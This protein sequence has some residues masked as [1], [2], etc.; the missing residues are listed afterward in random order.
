MFA[1]S[2]SAPNVRFKYLIHSDYRSGLH[3]VS[4]EYEVA[5]NGVI[6]GRFAQSTGHFLGN[7]VKSG[8]H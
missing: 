4:R 7:F 3:A 8:K 1:S 5:S 6:S 2:G